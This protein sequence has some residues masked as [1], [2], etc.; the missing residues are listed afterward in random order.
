MWPESRKTRPRRSLREAVEQ[1]FELLNDIALE[2]R[3]R[4]SDDVGGRL[5]QRLR[6][7]VWQAE[8]EELVRA[9]DP[10]DLQPD[11]ESHHYQRRRTDGVV[12]VD[13]RDVF[14]QHPRSRRRQSDVGTTAGSSRA[15]IRLSWAKN[16][17]TA[18][19]QA[20]ELPMGRRQRLD[21]F[22]VFTCSAGPVR[23]V[24]RSERTESAQ[25]RSFPGPPG[26][27]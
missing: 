3:C 14:Q 23:G 21:R 20:A 2:L 15:S 16:G 10:L 24:P 13:S 6:P 7:P 1:P 17:G 4:T 11:Q 22:Q 25:R 26:R 8:C 9:G 18:L 27:A 5:G 12:L 19:S